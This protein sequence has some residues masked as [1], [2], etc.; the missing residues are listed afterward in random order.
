MP[1]GKGFPLKVTLPVTLPV[2]GPPQ[3]SELANV[4]EMHNHTLENTRARKFNR[5][6]ISE[7]AYQS[8]PKGVLPYGLQAAHQV[9]PLML[10]DTLRTLPSPNPT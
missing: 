8:D 7:I 2:Y 9:A 6:L 5:V 3:P 10:A 4:S 1:P